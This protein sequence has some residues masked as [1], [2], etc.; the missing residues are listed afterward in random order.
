VTGQFYPSAGPGASVLRRQG[1]PDH[2]GT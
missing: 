1:V 2:P